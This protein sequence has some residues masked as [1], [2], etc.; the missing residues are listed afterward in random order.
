MTEA[1]SANG[2]LALD[3]FMGKVKSWLFHLGDCPKS[4]DFL[5][6]RKRLDEVSCSSLGISDI[7]F[8]PSPLDSADSHCFEQ[9]RRTKE[10]FS[11]ERKC[12]EKV[13]GSCPQLPPW[14]AIIAIKTVFFLISYCNMQ[15]TIKTVF[16]ERKTVNRSSFNLFLGGSRVVERKNTTF[17]LSECL[18]FGH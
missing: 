4:H 6:E 11:E 2:A 3:P 8:S 15:L 5:Y 13:S 1:C 7:A 17:M 16:R 18:G 10:L 12:S 14:C 9:T